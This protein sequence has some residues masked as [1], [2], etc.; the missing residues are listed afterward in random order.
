ML[1]IFVFDKPRVYKQSAFYTAGD[2]IHSDT[3][4]RDFPFMRD[5]HTNT[6]GENPNQ[7]TTT[8]RVRFITNN[9]MVWQYNSVKD[10]RAHLKFML[11]H[12]L[13]SSLNLTP[14][15]LR[16]A[17][18]IVQSC[19]YKS[20]EKNTH[21]HTNIEREGIVRALACNT[22][23]EKLSAAKIIA[24]QIQIHWNILSFVTWCTNDDWSKV[25]S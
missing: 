14:S 1:E 18:T 3:S 7:T 2:T 9:K 17:C 10:E 23:G 19:F 15:L 5:I 25:Q 6:E 12:R 11:W 24:R 4:K 8:I 22:T 20:C 13:Y 21:T 16:P